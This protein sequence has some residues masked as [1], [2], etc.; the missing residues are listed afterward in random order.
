MYEYGSP[1]GIPTCQ[2]P[3]PP[4]EHASH[5][6]TPTCSCDPLPFWAAEEKNRTLVPAGSRGKRNPVG[7]ALPSV[8]RGVRSRVHWDGLRAGKYLDLSGACAWG[9]G[10]DGTGGGVRLGAGL[11]R[12]GGVEPESCMLLRLACE[13]R[14]EMGRR[15]RVL[16]ARWLLDPRARRCCNGEP[17]PL[18]IVAFWGESRA[19]HHR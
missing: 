10:W 12:A 7:V 13:G 3:F 11:G 16:G 15:S 1:L 9:V 14:S 8:T 18:A 5:I 17:D 4:P 2:R 6:K 19:S